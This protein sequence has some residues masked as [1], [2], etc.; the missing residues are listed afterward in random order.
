M[1]KLS[2]EDRSRI[3]ACLVEGNSQRATCRMTGAAKK[4]VARLAAELGEACE[5]HALI[6]SKH[7]AQILRE[8]QKSQ[9]DLTVALGI[10]LIVPPI[11]SPTAPDDASC[12]VGLMFVDSVHERWPKTKKPLFADN[13]AALN[14]LLCHPVPDYDGRFLVGIAGVDD[15]FQ[16]DLQLGLD[17]VSFV[18]NEER[19]LLES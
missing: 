7:A 16:G 2:I 14:A 9:P 4:T 11:T 3:V 10:S 1:N 8:L 5:L 19:H 18:Q 13:L 12:A 6:S 17:L 15:G